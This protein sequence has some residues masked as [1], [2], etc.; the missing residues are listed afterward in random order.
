MA[1]AANP[2]VPRLLDRDGAAAYLSV[3]AD[4]IDRLI[5]TGALSIVRL[6]AARHR[7]GA[8]VAANCRRVLLDRL[9]L[10]RLVDQCRESTEG[11]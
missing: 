8:A 5:S 4:T 3:S 1:T 9:Q 6:P 2:V 10:D 11:A 7:N